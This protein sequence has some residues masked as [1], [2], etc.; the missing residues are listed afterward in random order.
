MEV[1]LCRKYLCDNNVQSTEAA[2]LEEGL[3]FPKWKNQLIVET[4]SRVH[5]Y[6]NISRIHHQCVHQGE[7]MPDRLD[8]VLQ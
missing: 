3:Q 7:V 5:V 6:N 4:F 8:K 1:L 2:N